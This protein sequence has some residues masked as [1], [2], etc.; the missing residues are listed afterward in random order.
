[1]LMMVE[2]IPFVVHMHLLGISEERDRE[3]MVSFQVL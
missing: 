1:M 2:Y 3:E